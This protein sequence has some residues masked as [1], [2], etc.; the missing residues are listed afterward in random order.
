MATN[1]ET[2]YEAIL[3]RLRIAKAL[4][5]RNLKLNTDSKLV[6]GHINSEYEAEEERIKRYLKLT[7]QLISHFDDVRID[8]V[9]REENL[10]AN[11]VA[12][13]ASSNGYIERPGLYME[14][15]TVPSIKGLLVSHI[16]S[17]NSWMDPILT[18]IK[19]GKLPLDLSEARKV[20]VWSSRFTVLN[21]KLYKR[22]FSLP[23][24]KCLNSEDVMY[25]LRKIHE[26]IC[27]NHLGPRS[28]VGKVVRVG[29]F[30]LT[31][32]KDAVEVV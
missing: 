15:Q 5:A 6:V 26:G 4:G 24:L 10:E 28:L 12:K 32:Q 29:Y 27:G 8:Q 22:G 23:Y 3:T 18:Y 20:K 19:D 14:V 7:N 31:M 2:E 16:Q 17:A 1:N 13:L 9:P 30:W 21:D 25:V 11:G